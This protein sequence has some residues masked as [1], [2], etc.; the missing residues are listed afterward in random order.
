MPEKFNV[1]EHVFVPEH[2]KLSQKEKEEVLNEYGISVKQ[3]PR[4]LITDP[5]LANLDVKQGD[6]IKISR[7]SPTAGQTV[8]YRSVVNE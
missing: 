6:V 4:I 7:K 3:L 8:Y 1:A 5:G 2:K